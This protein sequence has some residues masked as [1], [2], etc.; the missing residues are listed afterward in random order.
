MLQ[1]IAFYSI[2]T[3]N[4]IHNWKYILII[5]LTQYIF[6][7]KHMEYEKPYSF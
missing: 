7:L 1:T 2:Y 3:K 5:G 4:R 6:G